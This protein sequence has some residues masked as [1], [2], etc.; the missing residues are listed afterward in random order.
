MT[1]PTEPASAMNPAVGYTARAAHGLEHLENVSTYKQIGL[2]SGALMYPDLYFLR[3]VHAWVASF[4]APVLG[5][6]SALR[7]LN[8]LW[9]WLAAIVLWALIAS[10]G[11]SRSARIIGVSFVL[12][13][14][15]WLLHLADYSAHSLSFLAYYAG[16]FWLL[17]LARQSR[18]T[19]QESLQHGVALGLALLVYNTSVYLLVLYVVVAIRRARPHLTA[20]AALL[21][22]AVA[23]AWDWIL[24]LAMAAASGAWREVP[25]LEFY[26]EYSTRVTERA[27]LARSMQAWQAYASGMGQFFGAAARH[28]AEFAGMESPVVLVTAFLGVK[29]TMRR[30]AERTGR[31]TQSL[32]MLGAALPLAGSLVWAPSATARG[33]LVYATS[34]IVYLVAAIG[35]ASWLGAAREGAAR[36][37]RTAIV[38]AV[39]AAHAL[40]NGSY[41]FGQQGPLKAYFYGYD[42]AAGSFTRPA[43]F[44][45][46]T[47]AEPTPLLLGGRAS[48]IEAGLQVPDT[49]AASL[50]PN[51][52]V[53]RSRPSDQDA[54]VGP[55]PTQPAGIRQFAFA[56]AAKSFIAASLVLAIVLTTRRRRTKTAAALVLFISVLGASG[57]AAVIPA[58]TYLPT[59]VHN[60]FGFEVS[61]DAPVI[62]SIDLAPD[63]LSRIDSAARPGDRLLILSAGA[64]RLGLRVNG[65]TDAPVSAQQGVAIDRDVARALLR[66]GRSLEVSLHALDGIPAY[67]PC[68]QR[69]SLPGRTLRSMD[70]REITGASCLPAVELRLVDPSGAPVF[71][72]F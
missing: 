29:V 56:A 68:W 18:F 9:W 28:V 12:G 41:L 13:G 30:V 67:A 21:A 34:C 66:D 1:I 33:Y 26:A 63:L 37:L 10:L 23:L 15:G 57:L 39:I 7:L 19:S 48:A 25:I 55:A 72:A 51:L 64:M 16:L 65:W 45:S 24:V 47:G 58:R 49:G 38:V 69:G 59:F 52:F 31:E 6:R 70:G 22:I 54:R 62:Y 50:P 40:W 71:V 3:P 5:A 42:I 27:Y 46:L 4:L 35:L 36:R 53:G 17:A 43:T 60:A 8:I 20:A 61:P 2:F 11:G 32:L 44:A 14:S